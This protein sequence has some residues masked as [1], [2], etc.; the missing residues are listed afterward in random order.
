[1]VDDRRRYL[2]AGMND[3]VAKPVDMDRLAQVLAGCAD[4]LACTNAEANCTNFE[5]DDDDGYTDCA[6]ATGCGASPVCDPGDGVVGDTC[7]APSDCASESGDDPLCITAEQGFPG[8]YCSEFCDPI[9]QDCAA[10][11][12]CVGSALNAVCLASCTIDDDCNP[13]YECSEVAEGTLA[14]MPAPIQ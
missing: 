8:G 14:C 4:A 11:A 1:M 9:A 5:D 12:V 13:G 3:H 2:D 10:G 6:D 7:D